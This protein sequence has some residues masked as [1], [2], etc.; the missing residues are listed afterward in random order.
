MQGWLFWQAAEALSSSTEQGHCR[1]SHE[2][3]AQPG[4]CQR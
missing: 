4:V 3:V 1:R 2:S